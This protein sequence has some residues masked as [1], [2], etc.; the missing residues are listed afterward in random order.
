MEREARDV[1][2]DVSEFSLLLGD[3]AVRDVGRWMVV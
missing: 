2:W 3:V 1:S